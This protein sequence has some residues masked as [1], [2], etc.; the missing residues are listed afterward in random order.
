MFDKF[1]GSGLPDPV[2]L[3]QFKEMLCQGIFIDSADE[4]YLFA[5]FAW[6]VGAKNQFAWSAAQALEKYIKCGLLLNGSQAKFGH[7]FSSGFRN[8]LTIAYDL[9]P[10]SIIRPEALQ[11]PPGF[12]YEF[13]EDSSSAIERFDLNGHAYQRYRQLGIELR[14]FDLHKLDKLCF[15]IRRVCVPLSGTMPD[16]TSC[17]N[18][19]INNPQAFTF[20][21][22][23]KS[24]IRKPRPIQD[25]LLDSNYAMWNNPPAK[26]IEFF[27]AFQEP[28]FRIDLPPYNT[29]FIDALK[30]LVG[31]SKI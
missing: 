9:L 1:P 22:K 27:Y 26:S 30:W 23:L 20:E 29:N 14:A 31:N 8:L 11:I 16:G 4:D 21:G 3:E 12:E 7:S 13:P 18:F 10:T 24:Q 15:S 19:L 25:L 5:R 2:K 28:A 17:R 6:H